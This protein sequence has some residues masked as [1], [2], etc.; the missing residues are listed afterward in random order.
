[1]DADEVCSILYLQGKLQEG[2][3]YYF[4]HTHTHTH[5]YFDFFF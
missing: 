1:M 3:L 5:N 4:L 2:F